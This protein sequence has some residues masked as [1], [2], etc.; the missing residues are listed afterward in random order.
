MLSLSSYEISARETLF[1]CSCSTINYTYW[2]YLRSKCSIQKL[3]SL[4]FFLLWLI[5]F[6][7][8]IIIICKIGSRKRGG[9]FLL[10]LSLYNFKFFLDIEDLLTKISTA[11]VCL[12]F[13]KKYVYC[14]YFLEIHWDSSQHTQLRNIFFCSLCSSSNIFCFLKLASLFYNISI[15]KLV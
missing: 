15:W 11:A 7:I 6:S 2:H 1:F 13:Q 4:N 9:G 12:L 14:A 8:I 3:A 5:F 10:S